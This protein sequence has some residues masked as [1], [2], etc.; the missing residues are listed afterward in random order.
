M[1]DKVDTLSS[2]LE[3]IHIAL[4]HYPTLS[5]HYPGVRIPSMVCFHINYLQ[6]NV[7]SHVK[8]SWYRG[9]V[10]EFSLIYTAIPFMQ[11]KMN[12]TTLLF[13]FF[14]LSSCEI[15]FW[16]LFKYTETVKSIYEVKSSFHNTKPNIQFG[17]M[18][19]YWTVSWGLVNSLRVWK[20]IRRKKERIQSKLQIS[21]TISLRAREQSCTYLIFHRIWANKT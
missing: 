19:S 6:V 16:T 5:Q 1:G 20:A 10:F 13:F 11:L 18:C 3:K 8:L 17:S 4:G 14:F 9:F 2:L 21:K 12:L 15:I 7:Y